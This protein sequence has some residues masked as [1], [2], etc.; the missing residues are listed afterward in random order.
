VQEKAKVTASLAAAGFTAD[1]IVLQGR[2]SLGG[3]GGA[4]PHSSSA[5]T[6]YPYRISRNF[7]GFFRKIPKL[8]AKSIH[9]R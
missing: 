6:A 9:V 2:W 4:S 5:T 7:N 1:E 3:S 8:S